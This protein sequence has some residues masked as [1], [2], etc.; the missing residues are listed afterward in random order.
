MAELTATCWRGLDLTAPGHW[1]LAVA[2]GLDEPCQVTLAD[3]HHQRLSAKW[4][5]L[6]YRPEMS[7]LLDKFQHDAA[8]SKDS[9]LS[10]LYHL[11][12]PWEGVLQDTPSGQLTRVMGFFPEQRILVELVL[13][14]PARRD[15]DLEASI[16]RNT[17][18]MCRDT[19]MTHWK[20]HGVDLEIGSDFKLVKSTPNVGRVHWE[21]DNDERLHRPYGPLVI[22]RLSMAGGWLTDS[23]STWL[24]EHLPVGYRVLNRRSISVNGHPGQEVLSSKRL[25]VIRRWQGYSE[26]RV[27]RAW[28]C[29]IEDR[30]Y[31]ITYTHTTRE[32]ELPIPD[33]LAIHCCQEEFFHTEDADKVRPSRKERP[34]NPDRSTEDFLRAVPYQ[35]QSMELKRQPDG[36]A[37]ASIPLEK[38]WYMVPPITWLLPYQPVR[39]L[40]LDLVGLSVLGLCDGHQ[41]VEKI[42]EIFAATNKL[43]FREAQLAVTRFLRLLTHRGVIALV[44]KKP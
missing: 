33:Q 17:R 26:L 21:F 2:S 3:R 37:V 24:P 42:I 23:L 41:S 15:V 31:R 7:L 32:S 6:T 40:E 14:W 36:T 4:K 22:E 18:P 10:D 11:P 1:E 19:E 12:E 29:P 43:T 5:L 16:L 44:G 20:A 27:D 9:R 35:N 13:A 8:Q 30:M 25:D 38:P 34:K 28:I 39:R